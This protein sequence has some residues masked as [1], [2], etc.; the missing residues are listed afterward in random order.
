MTVPS[1]TG[2]ISS[3][4]SSAKNN[5]FG[6]QTVPAD[7]DIA[8]LFVCYWKSG[9]P[10]LSTVTLNSVSFSVGADSNND[11]YEIATVYYL[12]NPGTGVLTCN[13]ANA[14]DEGAH[15]FLVYLK[16][17]DTSSP[18]TGSAVDVDSTGSQTTPSFNTSTNDM[19][20]VVGSAYGAT[21]GD[22]GVSSQTEQ[23]DGGNYNSVYGV[24]GSKT[25]VSGTTTMSVTWTGAGMANSL[26]AVS[27]AG[28]SGAITA[29]LD[30][31]L[32]TLTLSSSADADVDGILNETLGAMTLDSDAGVEIDGELNKTLGELTLTSDT[33][34]EIDASLDETLG[35][36][37]ASSE[38]GIEVEGTLNKTLGEMNL[39][40]EALV[41]IDGSLDTTLGELGLDSSGD[42][43]IDGSLDKTL[44]TIAVS[45]DT[46]VEIDANLS[47]TLGELTLE[48]NATVSD[49]GITA[50][51]DKTLGELIL[52]S[53]SKVRVDGELSSTLGEMTLVSTAT[54]DVSAILNEGLGELTLSSTLQIGDSGGILYSTSAYI[55]RVRDQDLQ[56]VRQKNKKMYLVREKIQE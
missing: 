7:A 19:C 13:W 42:S 36:M 25:G 8:L 23:S 5:N 38:A 14:P 53:S 54:V 46:D 35:E 29:T 15:F 47:K 33:D 51:L 22:A 50:T 17:V 1:I 30:E 55:Y 10:N 48:S 39:S 43:D 34:V 31:T 2:S 3:W 16:D 44:G 28:S 37:S 18:I 26:A 27:I 52:T 56:V 11:S 6:S 49:S 40:S 24:I 32:G 9:A 4:T 21:A 20:W 41:L 45:S 12:V